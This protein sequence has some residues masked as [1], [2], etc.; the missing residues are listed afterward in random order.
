[1]I[2]YRKLLVALGAMLAAALQPGAAPSIAAI[3]VGFF[4]AHTI[5]DSKWAKPA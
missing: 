4:G 1:M 5:A 3:A 2:G